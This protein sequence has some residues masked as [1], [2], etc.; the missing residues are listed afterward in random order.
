ML[1]IGKKR[2]LCNVPIVALILGRKGYLKGYGCGGN[3]GISEEQVMTQAILSDEDSRRY[4]HATRPSG[5][6]GPMR[7]SQLSLH[8]DATSQQRVLP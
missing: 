3:H 7:L 5:D 2:Q 8:Y 4:G 6:Y 1:W